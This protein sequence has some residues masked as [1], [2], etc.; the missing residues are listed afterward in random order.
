MF[1]P[2]SGEE[3]G[4]VYSVDVIVSTTEISAKSPLSA[5][6][7]VVI[8]EGGGDRVVPFTVSGGVMTFA[9]KMPVSVEYPVGIYVT[10]VSPGGREVPVK[11]GQYLVFSGKTTDLLAGLDFAELSLT[12]VVAIGAVDTATGS[13]GLWVLALVGVAVVVFM[14]RRGRTITIEPIGDETR[15][16]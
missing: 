15:T 13:S 16:R 5:R 10:H 11:Y 4:V 2:A 1:I 8:R 14:R 9:D 7:V 12:G 3:F 6:G